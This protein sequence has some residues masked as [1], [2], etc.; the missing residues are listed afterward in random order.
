M[1]ALEAELAEL[2]VAYVQLADA[3]VQS[4]A[5]TEDARASLQNS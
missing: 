2:K 3:T 4:K 5:D 1:V